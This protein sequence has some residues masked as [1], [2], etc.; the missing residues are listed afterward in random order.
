[1]DAAAAAAPAPSAAAAAN[2][3]LETLSA[4]NCPI[5]QAILAQGICRPGA[6]SAH[7]NAFLL[8]CSLLF[9]RTD[10]DRAFSACI[11][12]WEDVSDDNGGKKAAA[13]PPPHVEA[14]PPFPAQFADL[15]VV[16]GRHL[17]V[18]DP[19]RVAVLL[20][21]NLRNFLAPKKNVCPN[22]TQ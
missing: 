13:Q 12:G 8:T 3:D 20:T 2:A 9:F 10:H 7:E 17:P 18:A 11:D 21:G 1:V 16:F 6:C 4:L 5:Y 15:D 22:S 14:P 19:P